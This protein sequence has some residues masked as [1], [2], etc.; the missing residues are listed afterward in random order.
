MPRSPPPPPPNIRTTTSS[1]SASSLFHCDLFFD[2]SAPSS[3]R[4][5]LLSMNSS[6]SGPP[7]NKLQRNMRFLSTG[8]H[9]KPTRRTPPPASHGVGAKSR[10]ARRKCS[11]LH[12]RVSARGHDPRSVRPFSSVRRGPESSDPA[13]EARAA[14]APTSGISVSV[15]S[16][17]GVS[18]RAWLTLG[19]ILV[20]RRKRA[21][22]P[23]EWARP[24]CD[25]L[26]VHRPLVR[27]SGRLRLRNGGARRKCRT[28]KSYGN[29]GLALPV[30][31]SGH[32]RSRRRKFRLEGMISRARDGAVASGALRW[33]QTRQVH[34]LE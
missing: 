28:E 29:S 26:L 31:R 16:F 10:C 6:L 1:R 17:L 27:G 8:N 22:C 14:G 3:C 30:R 5:G 32:G 4:A 33:T 24:L 12:R 20:L 34:E 15:E 11:A 2:G 9:R 25:F 23:S 18:K 13:S 21:P 7:L 19:W